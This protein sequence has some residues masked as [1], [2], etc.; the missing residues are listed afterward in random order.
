MWCVW[1]MWC[2]CVCGVHVCVVCVCGVRVC[3]VCMCVWYV[4]V[5]GVHEVCVV[6]VNYLSH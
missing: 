5:C 3:V 2:A 4:Y 1:Y 6:C